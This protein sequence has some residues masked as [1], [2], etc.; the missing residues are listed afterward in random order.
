FGLTGT[1]GVLPHFYTE[2]MIMRRLMRDDAMGAFLDVFNHRLMSF[3]YR[4]W[5]KHHPVIGYEQKA[6]TGREPDNFTQYLFDLVGMGTPDLRGRLSIPDEA[7]LYYGGLVAQRPHSA[8]AVRGILRDYFGVPVEIDQFLGDW[9]P[10]REDDRSYMWTEGIHNELGGGAIA[11]D[12][13][14]DQ[15]ARFRIRVGPLGLKRFRSFLPE[16]KAIAELIEWTRFLVGTCMTFEVNVV[17]KA[18]EVPYCQL[19]DAEEE[20]PRLGWLGWLK[21]EEF[22]SDATDV[23]FTYVN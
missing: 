7:L 21:T 20:G 8:A 23:E 1:Q 9:Y 18:A 22:Q 4:A 5:E 12:A 2:H 6:A 10:L 16:G 15:Q 17:L 19:T 3:F 14:W 11:G 13:V